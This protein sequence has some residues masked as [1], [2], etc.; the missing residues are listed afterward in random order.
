MMAVLQLFNLKNL[1]IKRGTK[2]I[3]AFIFK[4]T[5]RKRGVKKGQ[6]TI[7]VIIAIVIIALALLIYFF[8]PEITSNLGFASDN[9]NSFLQ[10][11]LEEQI[12][13]SIE[14]ISEQGGSIEPELTYNYLGQEV[15]YLCYTDKY[16]L[17]CVMQIAHLRKH[18]Q[19]EILAYI[20]D[21]I[22][23]CMADLKESYE[24]RGYGVSLRQGDV[25]VELVPDNVLI[26]FNHTLT[27]NKDSQEIY[28]GM[29]IAVKTKVY[30]LV[31][32]AMN[33][34][35][36]EARYGDSE[37]TTYMNYYRDLKVEKK[38]ESDGTTVYILTNRDSKDKFQFASRSVAWPA[39]Y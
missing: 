3:N 7:F 35:N 33:I 9:P 14:I 27:L 36:W 24:S 4:K 11:C 19:N 34:L 10:D 5:M 12:T 26:N 20:S 29:Q 21:D 6:V 17:P 28:D 23:S 30:D 31:A 38:K 22:T 37:T 15:E 13:E 8:Y 2:F 32:I 25:E 1:T 16:Y 39:G 18:I